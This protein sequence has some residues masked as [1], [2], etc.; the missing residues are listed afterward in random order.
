MLRVDHLLRLSMVKFLPVTRAPTPA[1]VLKPFVFDH[2]APAQAP[3]WTLCAEA[4]VIEE[5]L[6]R[7][8]IMQ[9]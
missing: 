2:P 4:I 9:E 7:A 1:F 3:L 8:A 5:D 6:R